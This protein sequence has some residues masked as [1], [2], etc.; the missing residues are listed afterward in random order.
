MHIFLANTIADFEFQRPRLKRKYVAKR[1]TCNTFLNLIRIW[2]NCFQKEHRAH[3][4][5]KNVS[6]KKP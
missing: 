2:H 3:D 6:K 5:N 1:K 4:M